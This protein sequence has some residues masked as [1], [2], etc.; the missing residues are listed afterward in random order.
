LFVVVLVDLSCIVWYG[1]SS[2]DGFGSKIHYKKYDFL[3]HL[4]LLQVAGKTTQ[5]SLASD[6]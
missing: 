5:D 4:F 2:N 6:L 3:Q 1:D